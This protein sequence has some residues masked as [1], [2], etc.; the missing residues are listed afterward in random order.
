MEMKKDNTTR[1]EPHEEKGTG[2]EA[3]SEEHL[4]HQWRGHSLVQPTDPF[5]SA[6]FGGMLQND[7]IREQE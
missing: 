7:V 4:P 1:G 3:G 6:V 5:P 2:E